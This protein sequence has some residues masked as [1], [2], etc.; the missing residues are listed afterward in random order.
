MFSLILFTN[1]ASKTGSAT[2]SDLLLIPC[3]GEPV[4]TPH[5]TAAMRIG[6]SRRDSWNRR[7]RWNFMALDG[8]FVWR[9]K[10]ME[11]YGVRLGVSIVVSGNLL[12]RR[13]K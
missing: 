6:Q 4:T 7:A 2:A 3:I 9:W 10:G 11:L 8:S 12:H 5:N 13:F 1:I